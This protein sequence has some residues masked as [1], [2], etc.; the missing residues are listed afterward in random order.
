MLRKIEAHFQGQL[1]GKTIAIWGLAFKPRTD[2]IRESP[3]LVLID[4]LLEL[5]VRLQVHDPEAMQNVKDR[6]GDRLKYTMQ[7]LEALT[8][9]DGLAINTEW[10]EFRNPD[11]ADMKRRMAQPVI[12]DGRNLYQPSQIREAGFIYYSIGRTPIG[13]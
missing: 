9:A 10:G 13:P 11:L 1:Q 4:R 5:D 8:A 12:F 3:A 6:Y 2:D 7:P